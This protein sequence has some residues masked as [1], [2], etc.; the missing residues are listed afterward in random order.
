MAVGVRVRWLARLFANF[1]ISACHDVRRTLSVVVSFPLTA[2][3]PRHTWLFVTAALTSFSPSSSIRAQDSAGFYEIETKYIFGF[4]EGSGIGLEGE[5]EVSTETVARF[6]KRDGHYSASETKLEFETTPNQYIQLEMGALV[7]THKISGVTDLDD[8]NQVALSGAFGE[9]RYL[10]L[11][12]GP[13]SP[14]AVTL[15]VEPEWH[16]I[17]ETGGARVVNYGLET[18]INADLE[19]LKN[20]AYLGFNLLY[21]P[22]ATRNDM[23]TWDKES[24]FG[25]STAL[26][27]RVTPQVT[28]GAEVWYL[29]H[30]E[31]SWFNTFTGDAMF[32]GP[33]LYVRLAR[34]LFMTA[35]WNVQVAGRE[36]TDNGTL[37]L[38]LSEFT[39]HRAKLKFAYEF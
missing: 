29:R 27:Y 12:R 35:A 10:L 21:E 18:K 37:N 4:T 23:G 36:F 26:A 2:S 20:R 1:V 5:K 3:K 9:L 22:E 28:L 17:D 6:G 34:K 7:A 16:R 8:R 33:T 19:L 15:S 25:V 39:R 38:N 31:G 24:K 14:L 13:S 11:D 30:Y 32:V